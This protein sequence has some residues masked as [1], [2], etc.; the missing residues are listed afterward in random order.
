MGL[1]GTLVGIIG[2]GIGVPIGLVLG[3]LI[4]IYFGPQDV[5]KDPVSRAPLEEIDSNSLVD[6][7][8]ELPLWVMKPDYER[9][10]W[11]NKFVRHMWPY[12][13]KAI[14]GA[15]KSAMKLYLA[16]YTGR[17]K[18][19]SLEFEILSLGTLPPLIDGI[20]VYESNE[21]QL[22]FE[23]ALRWAGNPNMILAAKL[24]SAK[25]TVQLID[26]QISA[27]PRIILR[28]IVPTFPCFSSVVVSLMQKPKIDFG[29][30]VMGGDLMAIPGLYQFVQE[31]ISKEAAKLYLWPQTLEIPI[32]DNSKARVKKPVGILRVK[33]LR[34]YKLLKKDFLGSSDPYVQLS[35]S[36]DTIPARKTSVKMNNLNPEWNEEFKLSVKDPYTQV[37]ELR[38]YDWEKVGAH[39]NLGMQVVPLKQLTPYEK[40]EL[41]LDLLNSTNNSSDS[42][43]KKPR[44]QIMLEITFVPFLE[45]SKKFSGVPDYAR[46]GST[47]EAPADNLSGA[48]LL[49]VTA[50]G[51]EDVEG[52]N[53][54]NPYA[55]VLFKGE[56]KKTKSISK[57]RNPTWNE[58]FQFVLE[59]APSTDQIH[60]EVLSKRRGIGFRSKES[61]GHVDI[62]L[63]DV[64]HNG[65]INEKYHLINS[66]DGKIHLEIQWKVI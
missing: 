43:D 31:L 28:P 25:V 3:Y 36:G 44:G 37:L 8:P 4:F 2:F 42:H 47:K 62:N 15:I 32:L 9:V 60:I 45:D 63:A 49:L 18:L 34:A 61:L 57:N 11:L 55:V 30:K 5:I 26:L 59:E 39:D 38:L 1:L 21:S 46:N 16:E 20:K 41:T 24:L 22:F 19:D 13:D 52:K 33:V 51:A 54:N 12:L 23:L 48:G 6:L 64:V 66:Q 29:L 35:L 53:H 50:I 40:K 27:A 7:L 65:R 58:E 10:D 56:K 17:F 14:C